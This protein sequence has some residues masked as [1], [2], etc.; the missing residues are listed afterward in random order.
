MTLAAL[1]GTGIYDAASRAVLSV[2]SMVGPVQE[3]PGGIPEVIFN[4]GRGTKGSLLQ[5]S[6]PDQGVDAWRAFRRM[7]DADGMLRDAIQGMIDQG[8]PWL[9]GWPE[10][11]RPFDL[12][13]IPQG[14]TSLLPDFGDA[15]LDDVTFTPARPPPQTSWIPRYPPQTWDS[16]EP[17]PCAKGVR[18]LLL[19]EAIEKLDGWLEHTR[20]D[21]LRIREALNAG[22]RPEALV[23]DRPKAIA[24]GQSEMK[25]WARGKVW[26]CSQNDGSCCTLSQLDGLPETHLNIS[27][28]SQ[29]LARYPD[30]AL[31]SHLLEGAKLEA[32]VELQTVMVPHLMSLTSEHGQAS[33]RVCV[34]IAR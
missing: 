26:N 21:M 3:N 2:E 16:P 32:E 34:C 4:T 14:A 18:D 33:K 12:E 15:R 25:G 6:V 28:L 5:R 1:K 7:I 10:Q 30:Q 22:E 31:M 8:D 9:D 19:P 24:I 11:I 29:R 27:F 20:E 23:R 13:M 17:M